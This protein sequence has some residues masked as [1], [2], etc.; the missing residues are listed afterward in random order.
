MKWLIY[1]FLYILVIM[2]FSSCRMIHHSNEYFNHDLSLL[3][4]NKVLDTPPFSAMTSK[5]VPFENGGKNIIY[6]VSNFILDSL[7]RVTNE[8]IVNFFFRRDVLFMFDPYIQYG[9]CESCDSIE[10]SAWKHKKE[11]YIVGF[12]QKSNELQSY[13]IILNEQ[14]FEEHSPFYKSELFLVNV[15]DNEQ[16]NIIQ[17]SEY[18]STSGHVKKIIT[19]KSNSKYV[20]K[21]SLSIDGWVENRGF[22]YFTIDEKGEVHVKL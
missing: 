18:F 6:N 2:T 14:Y 8:G 21:S 16:T 10:Y 19:K 9:C 17:L 15:Y 4:Y 1:F 12:E 22:H 5:S 20:I 13:Y 3:R 7:N 11:L